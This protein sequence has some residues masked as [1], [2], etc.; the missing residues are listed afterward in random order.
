MEDGGQKLG[1]VLRQGGM[2]VAEQRRRVEADRLHDPLREEGKSAEGARDFG[3]GIGKDAVFRLGNRVA[4]IEDLLEFAGKEFVEQQPAD[5]LEEAGHVFGTVRPHVSPA[6]PAG[7]P[8]DEEAADP[9][10]IP[11]LGPPVF[12]ELPVDGGVEGDLADLGKAELENRGGKGRRVDAVD[13][14][15][16]VGQAE[17]SFLEK[18]I[19]F[20]QGDAILHLAFRRV[21]ERPEPSDRN[22]APDHILHFQDLDQLGAERHLGRRGQGMDREEVLVKGVRLGGEECGCPMV[23]NFA[24][25]RLYHVLHDSFEPGSGQWKEIFLS[26]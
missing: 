5:V 4:R 10:S 24:T 16:D 21:E 13:V 11:F 8:G 7:G 20:D 17:H 14:D 23:E 1:A 6:D 2:M 15:R 12:G 26:Y 9:E 18:G 19:E 22:A 3:V 25:L